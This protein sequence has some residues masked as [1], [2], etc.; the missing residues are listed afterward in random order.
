MSKYQGAIKKLRQEIEEKQKK[1]Q[2]L[3][4]KEKVMLS[5]LTVVCP[6]CGGK[7][8]ERYTDA[9]GSGDTRDCLTCRG[10][11]VVGPIECRCGHTISVDMIYLRRQSVPYCPWCGRLVEPIYWL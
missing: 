7:K 5:G 11:G 1:I 10:Y 9:A 6:S 3:E 4:E 8:T 2:E